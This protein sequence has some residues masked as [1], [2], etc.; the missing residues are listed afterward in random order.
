VPSHIS[1][2][3]ETATPAF[4]PLPS[5]L[6]KLPSG[7]LVDTPA[8]ISDGA[9]S[10]A[11]P[12]PTR[13]PFPTYEPDIPIQFSTLGMLDAANGWAID[14]ANHLLRTSNGGNT[15]QDVTPPQGGFYAFSDSKH[16][17]AVVNTLDPYIMAGC[18]GWPC[19]LTWQTTDAG[20][21]WVRGVPFVAGGPDYRPIA[22][23]FSG[24]TSGWFLLVNHIGMSN[25]TYEDL[26]KT[27]DSGL[28]W[29]F[30]RGDVASL[31]LS[32]GMVFLNELDGWI[33]DNCSNVGAVEGTR[34]VDFLNGQAAPALARTSDGGN[35]WTH[36]SPLPAPKVFPPNI[37][38]PNVDANVQVRCGVT[39]MERISTQAFALQWSCFLNY[40]GQSP[41]N[42][43]YGYLTADSGQT[44]RSW[45]AAGNE[46]FVDAS[47]GWR[48]LISGGDDPNQLQQTTDG[49]MTWTTIR[50]VD[51]LRAQFDFI[52]GQVGWAIVSDGA[53]PALIHTVD[54]GTT[55]MEIKPVAAP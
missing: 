2:G 4:H 37:T 31:C 48:L 38:D 18:K 39:R 40:P 44:W 43:S 8:P 34:L 6:T 19:N 50:K 26:L 14:S 15:W 47:T 3:A 17:W 20:Q 11:T 22:M 29:T 41:V 27:R 10:S 13:T 55:W 51:W 30:V 45:L 24:G 36:D 52:N 46:S 35:L 7:S 1:V 25:T 23:E 53:N 49:G 12:L 16:A 32:G 21:T 9:A 28:S 33:G 42:F 5:I 54:G